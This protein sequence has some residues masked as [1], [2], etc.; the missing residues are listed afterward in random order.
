[1]NPDQDNKTNNP[2]HVM[3]AN[4]QVICEVKRHPVG[5]IG[6]YGAVGF[7]LLL[8]AILVYVVAPSIFSDNRSQVMAYGSL[9]FLILVI[10][11]VG[12]AFINNIIYWGNRWYVTTDSVTQVQQTGLFNKQSSQ[13]S[14]ENL[15]DVTA[16]KNGILAQMFNFGVI[17]CE[18]AG[19]RSKFVFP[20]CP[21]PTYY[22]Q[23]ILNARERFMQDI[24]SKES[25][26]FEAS[27]N[28]TPPPTPTQ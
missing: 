18:T 15:E 14:L 23:E 20:F 24:R 21:N 7:L 8:S 12:F 1:M 6:V 10:I 11:G 5:L 9:L 28:Q 22:A 25:G 3:Q 26:R 17:K 13:L 27:Q 2:L 4:E 19:E 16:E